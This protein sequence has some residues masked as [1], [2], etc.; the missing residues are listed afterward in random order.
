MAKEIWKPVVGFEGCYEV[1]SFG[2][3]RSLS[4]TDRHGKFH[5]ARMMKTVINKGVYRAL[6]LY[7]APRVRWVKVYRLVAEAFLGP[8]PPGMQCC[9]NDGDSFNDRADNL[10]WDTPSNNTLDMHKH[11]RMYAARARGTRHPL[12]RFTELQ[13]REIRAIW[14]TGRFTVNRL[15]RAYGVWPN[16]I[17]GIVLYRTWRHVA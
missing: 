11:G 3:V 13:I 15:A 4:R 16:A 14:R 2:R 8:C 6:E 7:C 5:H 10:R 12:S 17:K 9:H 1:S